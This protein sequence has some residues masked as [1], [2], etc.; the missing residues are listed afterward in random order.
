ME[1]DEKLRFMLNHMSPEGK[2]KAYA[3]L[4]RLWLRYGTSAR[5]HTDTR[6]DVPNVKTRPH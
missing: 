4:Q 1:V 5:T 6:T 3:L 2:Q